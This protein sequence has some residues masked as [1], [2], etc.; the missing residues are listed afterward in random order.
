MQVSYVTAPTFTRPADTTAYAQND[1]VANSTT[2]GSVVPLKFAIPWKRSCIVR[3][4]SIRKSDGADVANATFILHL[5]R[6]SPTLANGDNGALSTDYAE[7]IG[8]IAPA[9]MTSYTDDAYTSVMGGNFYV[10]ANDRFIY[11]ILVADA[12]YQGL[13][14]ET[15]TVTLVVEQE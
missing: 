5:Y 12:A 10:D 13:S 14:E 11:G 4:C 7:K 2:A 3:G 9:A 1:V 15:F 8:T 6:N